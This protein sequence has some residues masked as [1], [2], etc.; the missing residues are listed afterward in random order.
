MLSSTTALPA[1]AAMNYYSKSSF[2]PL[3]LVSV[4]YSAMAYLSIAC[5]KPIPI[6]NRGL[7]KLQEIPKTVL[8]T[9]KVA[10]VTGS[11]TGIGFETSKA[12]VERGYQVILACRSQDKAQ[13][14][15]ERMERELGPSAAGKAV[16]EGSLDLSS[17]QSVHDFSQLIRS[18]Y[19]K[20]D[21]LVNN[22]GRNTSGPS[23]KG[24]DLCFQTNFLGHFLLTQ[25]LMDPLLQADA[26]RVVNLSSVMHHYCQADTHD[27]T[28]WRQSALFGNPH[29]RESSYSAS[30]LAALYFTMELNRRYRANGLRSIAVNPGAVN[31]D[32]WRDYPPLIQAINK[33]IFLNNQQ[34]SYTSVAASVLDNLP[35]D[36]IYLQPY[37]QVQGSSSTPFPVFEMLGPFVG[38]QAIQ[39]RLPKDGTNGELTARILWNVSEDL[40]STKKVD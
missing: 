5:I 36:V 28:Y 26:P 25:N 22:A 33:R 15:M 37:H 2:N 9:P 17:F 29:S 21:L 10:I 6:L 31:S 34:G 23:E 40:V 27:E 13:Q 14:A 38:Y 30:K 11:N 19:D 35:P 32:I 24:L 8:T 7:P 20:I 1:R 4:L 39:P 18:K 16:Y 3:S 12:L